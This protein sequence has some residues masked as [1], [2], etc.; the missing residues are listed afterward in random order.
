MYQPFST[1]RFLDKDQK[2]I[3]TRTLDSHSLKECELP[4]QFSKEEL[5]NA[6]VELT[7][8]L[9]KMRFMIYRGPTVEFYTRCG[10]TKNQAERLY[11]ESWYTFQK[12]RAEGCK[13]SL[14]LS[15]LLVLLNGF[16]N[17]SVTQVEG[18]EC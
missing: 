10:Y 13:K 2:V 4:N 18:R 5:V 15:T 12:Q 17:D 7:D 3:S 1:Y 9:D 16:N 11:A 8:Q 14:A 6:I